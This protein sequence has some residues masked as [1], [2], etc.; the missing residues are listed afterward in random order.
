MSLRTPLEEC[1]EQL[2]KGCVVVMKKSSEGGD[3]C[4]PDNQR[5]SAIVV[6]GWD[7]KVTAGGTLGTGAGASDCMVDVMVHMIFILS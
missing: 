5:L 7:H 2:R 6:T 3:T 1:P 4:F